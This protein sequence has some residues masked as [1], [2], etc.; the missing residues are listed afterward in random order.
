[1]KFI[2][3]FVLIFHTLSINL[4]HGK[5]VN[6]DHKKT[7]VKSGCDLFEGKWVYDES[8]P[9]YETSQ[10]P[11]IEKE[12]DCQN[13]GRPDQFYLKYRWQPTGCNLPRYTFFI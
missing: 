9:L 11:F 8:Y 12:F 13:N 5:K 6:I 10:C 2:I 4:A 1:M 3:I 7:I